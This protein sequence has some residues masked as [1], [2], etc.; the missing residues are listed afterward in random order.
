M[1]FRKERRKL[2][3]GQKISEDEEETEVNSATEGA[4]ETVEVHELPNEV[5]MDDFSKETQSTETASE[6]DF[7]DEETAAE[8]APK[9]FQAQKL[10]DEAV[11]DDISKEEQSTETVPERTSEN[12]GAAV[13]PAA[14]ETSTPS[15]EEVRSFEREVTQAQIQ[16]TTRS[17]GSV[18][19]S[20][21]M[22]DSSD[23]GQSITATSREDSEVG[24]T[25]AP[26]G[27]SNAVA[28]P[29]KSGTPIV[30]D[31]LVNPTM[32]P[33]KESRRYKPLQNTTGHQND[34]HEAP[35]STVAPSQPAPTATIAAPTAVN[36][37]TRA[38]TESPDTILS[39]ETLKSGAPM[40][41]VQ[42]PTLAPESGELHDVL[43][44]QTDGTDRI[45]VE[46]N[47]P[48]QVEA[49]ADPAEWE[50]LPS[51]TL[52]IHPQPWRLE[53]ERPDLAQ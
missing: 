30:F 7:E 48:E 11:A 1:N 3:L 29:P 39:N 8:D 50:P 36:A 43:E 18:T 35:S 16:S 28:L 52:K 5:A 23:E 26:S 6:D 46:S 42:L 49:T 33:V 22:E 2:R 51:W 37:R 20:I 31:R 12:E 38:E 19:T 17:S 53:Q 9:T 14:E 25:E 40:T 45:A 41:A 15:A 34:E 4:P 32:P 24:T 47:S 27:F 10:R 44:D 21:T 13:S